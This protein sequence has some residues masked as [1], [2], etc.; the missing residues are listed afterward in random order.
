M[1]LTAL[2]AFADNYIWTLSGDDGAAVVVDPGDAVLVQ[3]LDLLLHVLHGQPNG[4][5]EIVGDEQ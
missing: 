3:A 1:R 2:P 4:V 5:V